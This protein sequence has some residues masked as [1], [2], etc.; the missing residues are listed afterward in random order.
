MKRNLVLIVNKY[1]G[2]NQHNRKEPI[3]GTWKTIQDYVITNLKKEFEL[4][5][6]IT[7]YGRH[8]FKKSTQQKAKEYANQPTTYVFVGGDDTLDYGIT[9]LVKQKRK[10]EDPNYKV[11]YIP[12][13]EGMA[14]KHAFGINSLEHAIKLIMQENSEAI[15]LLNFNHHRLGFYGGQGIFGRAVEEREKTSVNGVKGFIVPAI[16]AYVSSF[17]EKY[18]TPFM[19]GEHHK[20]KITLTHDNIEE[21]IRGNNLGVLFSKIPNIG[22]GLPLMPDSKL[23]DGLIHLGIYGP[24]GLISKKTAEKLECSIDYTHFGGDYQGIHHA[25]ITVEKQAIDMIL[26]TKELRKKKLLI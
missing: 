24:F 18:I 23:N 6:E 9:A 14:V 4:D 10:L 15:D 25:T 12:S 5:I 8:H 1:A 16:K 11:A 3:E 19:Y 21:E 17:V 13:G 26:N 20:S 2:A 7:D 22:G